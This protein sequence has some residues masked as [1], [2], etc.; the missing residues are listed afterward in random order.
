MLPARTD[1][2]TPPEGASSAPA[3]APPPACLPACWPSTA[4]LPVDVGKEGLRLGALPVEEGVGEQHLACREGGVGPGRGLWVLHV[5]AA[6]LQGW[7]QGCTAAGPRLP[8]LAAPGTTPQPAP[9]PP[10]ASLYFFCA[11]S[12]SPPRVLKVD[13]PAQEH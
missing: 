1:A 10:S 7:Q 11:R 9:P 12:Y 2:G 13:M 8:G 3:C 5:G 4:T 6:L